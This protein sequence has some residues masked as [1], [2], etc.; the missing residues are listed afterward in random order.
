MNFTQ[1]LKRNQ[2][3]TDVREGPRSVT[4]K[5]LEDLFEEAETYGQVCIFG[6]SLA[7]KHY[8]VNIAFESIPGVTLEASSDYG[9]RIEA[10]FEQAIERAKEIV[11]SMSKKE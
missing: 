6:S 1:R 4:L 10:S 2:V 7:K 11:A 8:T 9:L 3:S 5:T